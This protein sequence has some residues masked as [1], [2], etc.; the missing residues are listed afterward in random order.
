M[1]KM[2]CSWLPLSAYLSFDR[3]CDEVHR[4]LG[5]CGAEYVINYE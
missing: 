3:L 4:L 2:K 1:E 5:S